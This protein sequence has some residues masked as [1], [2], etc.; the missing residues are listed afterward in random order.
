[1]RCAFVYPHSPFLSFNPPAL[2][3]KKTRPLW[4]LPFILCYAYMSRYYSS[5]L[6]TASSTSCVDMPTFSKSFATL[7]HTG[8]WCG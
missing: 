4:M 6:A 1:M 7:C 3:L 5:L 8:P 2:S